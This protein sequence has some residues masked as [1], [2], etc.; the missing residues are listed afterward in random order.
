[1]AETTI[2]ISLRASDKASATIQKVAGQLNQLGKTTGGGS[3]TGGAGLVQLIDSGVKTA[4]ASLGQFGGA[5][6]KLGPIGV[7]A[8]LLVSGAIKRMRYEAEEASK[9]ISDTVNQIKSWS[10]H[11]DEVVSKIDK[12]VKLQQQLNTLNDTLADADAEQ[13]ARTRLGN[14]DLQADAIKQQLEEVSAVREAASKQLAQLGDSME[15]VRWGHAVWWETGTEEANKERIKAQE[16]ARKVILDSAKKEAD[17]QSQLTLLDKQREV[18]IKEVEDEAR[19]KIEESNAKELNSLMT[20]RSE[21]EKELA[22]LQ[23]LARAGEGSFSSIFESGSHETSLFLARQDG[24]IT[25]DTTSTEIANNVS[26]I[27][28][29]L[30]GINER[31]AQLQAI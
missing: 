8:G 27:A 30:A 13:R 5:L 14:L 29:E 24:R 16:E 21:M 9:A 20:Q 7:A 10:T 4:T 17:L 25:S 28:T 12:Q 22:R 1:M 11:A 18:A 15:D 19:K 2:G 6:A 31:I 26:T 23:R 3:G